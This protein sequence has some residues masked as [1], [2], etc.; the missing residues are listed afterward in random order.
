MLTVSICFTVGTSNRDTL[1]TRC[2][3]QDAANN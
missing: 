1:T 3:A 2:P